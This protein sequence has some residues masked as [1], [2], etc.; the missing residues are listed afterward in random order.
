MDTR[1]KIQLGA[2]ELFKTKGFKSVTMDEIAKTLQISK[3]TIYENFDDKHELIR[4]IVENE[5]RDNAK[6]FTEVIENEENIYESL[7]K[8]G[9]IQRES[10]RTSSPKLYSDLEKYYS[11]ILE[12]IEELF[13]NTR[14]NV[15]HTII[16]RGI[17]CGFLAK[18]FDTNVMQLVIENAMDFSINMVK[19]KK[20]TEFK[21]HAPIIIVLRGIST[22]K[23]V[24]YIDENWNKILINI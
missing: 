1:E 10:I 8:L 19:T 16:Q 6:R 12:N 9:R 3:R 23:G 24:K 22:E 7:E 14:R 2:Y 13:Y 18:N 20:A 4:T 5:I 15:V 11:S 17:K 21:A